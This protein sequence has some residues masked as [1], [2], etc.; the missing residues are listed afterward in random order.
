M[1]D[2]HAADA[3]TPRSA[4]ERAA[5]IRANTRLQAPPHVPEIMLHLRELG[6][7][8]LDVLTVAGC[9][10]MQGYLFS[11]ALPAD[12]VDALIAKRRSAR[13]AA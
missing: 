2:L 3:P 5:F 1:P 10:Q 8:D 7:L 12:E 11:R 9:N 4:G 13:S 6:L